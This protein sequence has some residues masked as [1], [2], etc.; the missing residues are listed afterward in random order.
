MMEKEE[1]FRYLNA[2]YDNASDNFKKSEEFNHIMKRIED[3]IS[4]SYGSQCVGGRFE[5]LSSGENNLSIVVCSSYGSSDNRSCI[6]YDLAFDEDKN[7]CF[8]E[9]FASAKSDGTVTK[10]GNYRYDFKK[11][12]GGAW[13]YS[14]V[15]KAYSLQGEFDEVS[16]GQIPQPGS[17][18]ALRYEGFDRELLMQIRY[19][20]PA[21]VNGKFDLNNMRCGYVKVA[22]NVERKEW[23]SEEAFAMVDVV[24]PGTRDVIPIVRRQ[25]KV[26]RTGS[27]IDG[28]FRNLRVETSDVY[29]LSNEDLIAAVDN[30]NRQSQGRSR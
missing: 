21:L 5:V 15:G 18:G 9:S 6:L 26:E 3:S 28:D 25:E 8:L 17:L 4:Y 22:S 27:F 11:C 20:Q 30:R 12:Y 24:Y 10:V 2:V 14:N 16:I 29:Y 7:L 13:N 1:K 23:G 19:A